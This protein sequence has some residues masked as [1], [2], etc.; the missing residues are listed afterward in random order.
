MYY[1]G[2]LRPVFDMPMFTA[3]TFALSWNQPEFSFDVDFNEVVLSRLTG[4][5][6]QLCED[7]ED[8]RSEGDT[9]GSSVYMNLQEFSIYSALES[10]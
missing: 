1:A 3:T 8:N 6:R 9:G 5:S 7:F 2:A 10:Q 4:T